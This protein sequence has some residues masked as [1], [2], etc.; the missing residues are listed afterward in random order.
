MSMLQ[1]MIFA[2]GLGTRLRPLTDDRPKALVEVAGR[3]LLGH[4]ILKMKA[5]GFGRIV[6]NVHH[7]GEQIADYLEA[8]GRFGLDVRVSDERAALLDTG[9]GL[10]RAL[11]LLDPAEPVVVHNADVVTDLDLA[12]LCAAATDVG[13]AASLVVSQRATSRYLL[14]DPRG[15]ALRGWM[16]VVPGADGGPAEV[17]YRIGGGEAVRCAAADVPPAV[18]E[19]LPMA[20]SGIHVVTPR[21]YP[22]LAAQSRDVFSVVD[23]YLAV[24]R[25][26]TVCAIPHPEGTQW[27]DCGRVE[28]LDAAARILCSAA[29]GEASATD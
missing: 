24:C 23:F 21:L 29:Y 6:V 10:K 1:A 26:Q 11:P 2:A 9:G 27:V 5:Q 18:A 7:H 19:W 16:R 14:F 8:N 12:G 20:F 13:A 25:A 22:V 28:N 15:G 3:P 17:D 4:L